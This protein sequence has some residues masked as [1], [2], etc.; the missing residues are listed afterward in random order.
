MSDIPA[1]SLCEGGRFHDRLARAGLPVGTKDR[2]VLALALVAIGA[3]PLVLLSAAAGTAVGGVDHPLLYDLGAWVR[4]AV[5]VPLMVLAE[6]VADR[7][8]GIVVDLFRRAGLIRAADLP[9]FESA[10]QRA[11]RKATSDT[12][13]LVLLL[14]ALTLPHI[15]V[16]SLPQLQTGTAWFGSLRG[17]EFHISAAGRWY[18][19]VSL[20]LVQYL[21][22]RWLW[23]ILAWWG[24]LWRISKLR[25]AWAAGHPDGAGGL[26]FLAWSPRAFRMVFV[27]LSALAAAS[28]SNQ[29]QFGGQ[30]LAD[31]RGP[32]LAFILCECLLLLAPQFFFARE[33]LRTRYRGLVGYG[34]TA[35]AMSR[36]FERRWTDADAPG[37]SKLLDSSEP[38]AMI[39]YAGTY[40]L[41]V[42]MRP[43]GL[44]LREGIG[45]VL[46]LV[47]PFLPLLLYQYS[48]KELLQG[49][50]QLVR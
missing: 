43:T 27:G 29:I 28:V 46:P 14:I 19:W 5:V 22:L 20:P 44:S 16:A 8:L 26:G 2:G 4:F 47:A 34:L 9:V 1:F 32:I 39:D 45:I 38:S 6:P 30:T 17:N 36:E 3:V 37:G 13:D 24:L 7:L 33:M 49:V 12:A 25:L 42:A 11:S 21:L 31:A 35:S 23:R 40:G 18:A 50:L 10:V 48:V 15:L 41:V